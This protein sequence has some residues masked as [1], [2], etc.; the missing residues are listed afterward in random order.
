VSRDLLT[1]GA[2]TAASIL[3]AY[4]LVDAGRVLRRNAQNAPAALSCLAEGFIS[5][6]DSAAMWL[7][8]RGVR[9]PAWHR[10]RHGQHCA[11]HHPP[12][13]AVARPA[14]L[15]APV[16]RP[17]F[18]PAPEPASPAPVLTG[19]SPAELTVDLGYPVAR[20]G[21]HLGTEPTWERL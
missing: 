11:R 15:P 4:G 17:P 2:C 7:A 20:A 12:A 13:V 18:A 8:L 5:A 1:I 19:C 21:G 10:P 14:F 9:M 16:P 3:M 6:W